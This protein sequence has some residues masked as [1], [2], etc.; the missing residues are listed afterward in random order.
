MPRKRKQEAEVKEE[1]PD[2]DENEPP[3]HLR[4]S[5]RSRTQVKKYEAKE[6]HNLAEGDDDYE[7]ESSP[8]RARKAPGAYKLASAS[9]LQDKTGNRVFQNLTQ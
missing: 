7:E 3:Q 9:C 4:R 2:V 8:V 5:K 6:E 1:A